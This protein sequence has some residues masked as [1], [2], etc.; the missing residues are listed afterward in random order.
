MSHSVRVTVALVAGLAAVGGSAHAQSD[1][2]GRVGR[3]A[4][5]QGNV[6]FHDSQQDG[7]SPALIN[8][9]LT[10]GDSLWTEPSGHD[11]VS[12]SGTRVRMDGSTQLDMLAID[13][14]QIRLQLD[15]GRIDIKAIN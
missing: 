9:P 7:W 1:P 3:L 10:S 5:L 13:D 14:G 12:L 2:P 15:Q 6:S 8:T 4:Y 11:E